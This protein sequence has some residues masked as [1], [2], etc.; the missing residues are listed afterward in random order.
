M[1]QPRDPECALDE[2]PADSS[3]ALLA[4]VRD[5]DKAALDELLARYVPRLRRWAHGR[6]P[7]WARGLADTSDVVQ[8]TLVR[9]FTRLETFEV[10]G[11]RA[12]DAYLRHVLFNRIREEVRRAGRRPNPTTLSSSIESDQDSP[13]EFAVGRETWSRFQ[14]ALTR[15]KPGDRDLVVARVERGWSNEQIAEAFGKP[16]ANAAR[17]A[18]ERALFRL[19][20]EM[21][22]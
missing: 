20:R 15:L 1:N 2:L 3:V 6:L 22:V 9:T 11:D 12:L 5:G 4:R 8:E 17:M 16:S 10:R 13:L 19:A 18:V 14:D 21:R 7:V